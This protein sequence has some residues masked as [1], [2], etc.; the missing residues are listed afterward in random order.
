MPAVTPLGMGCEAS[1]QQNVEANLFAAY[2]AAFDRYH[3]HK[4]EN[5]RLETISR[6][7]AYACAAGHPEEMI[8]PASDWGRK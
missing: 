3:A 5:A 7:N 8:D 1:C 6:Y 2:C 4:S